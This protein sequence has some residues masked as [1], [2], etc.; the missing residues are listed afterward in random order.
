LGLAGK[1]EA[2]RKAGRRSRRQNLVEPLTWTALCSPIRFLLSAQPS[3][4]LSRFP[5]KCIGVAGHPFLFVEGTALI[6]RT[7][8][9]PITCFR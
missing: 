7:R 4:H 5:V 6:S 9:R 2:F 3:S 1:P 8:N